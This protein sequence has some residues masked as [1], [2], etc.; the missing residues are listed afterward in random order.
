MQMSRSALVLFAIAAS[1]AQVADSFE[2]IKKTDAMNFL[3][4]KLNS[5]DMSQ[6]EADAEADKQIEES[7]KEIRK[8]GWRLIN[9]ISKE[10]LAHYKDVAF[11]DHPK[12]HLQPGVEYSTMPVDMDWLENDDGS[13]NAGKDYTDPAFEDTPL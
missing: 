13:H 3:E 1:V 9:G 12:D 2:A 10:E 5:V 8:E 4:K 6:K 7:N 11:N